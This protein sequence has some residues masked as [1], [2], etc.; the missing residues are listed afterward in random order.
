MILKS[1]SL[2]SHGKLNEL[3][4]IK[5]DL[6]RT[7]CTD[8]SEMTYIDPFSDTTNLSESGVVKLCDPV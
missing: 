2:L 6:R 3:P 1:S 7:L 5:V 8:G 4:F